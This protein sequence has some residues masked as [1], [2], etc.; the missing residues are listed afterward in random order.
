MFPAMRVSLSNLNPNDKYVVLMDVTPLDNKRHRYSYGDS[1][2]FV[3]GDADPPAPRKVF[4]HPDSPFT[5]LS[6]HVV[7]FEKVKL[8]NNKNQKH[9]S[10]SEPVI[11]D[12][13]IQNPLL[14]PL[15]SSHKTPNPFVVTSIK[16]PCLLAMRGT[17]AFILLSHDKRQKDAAMKFS[18]PSF[19][20]R[21]AS[22]FLVT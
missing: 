16:K 2:W 5:G 12:I 14:S 18:E 7:S 8:T 13:D 3:A 17:G 9:G 11:L 4:V 21:T 1:A 15:P 10:V 22:F 19:K 20:L 6:K